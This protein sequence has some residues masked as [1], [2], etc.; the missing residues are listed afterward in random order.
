MPIT[1]VAA[2][3]QT[4]RTHNLLEPA[5]LDEVTQ[6]LQARFTDPRE[7]A[8]DLVRR[9]WLTGFQANYIT[10]GKAA[11]L[12]LSSFI[13]L[14]NCVFLSRRGRGAPHG[15]CGSKSSSTAR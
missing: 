10:Q 8:R 2:L 9:G 15:A 6:S 4:L 3:I 1:P 5:Q 13:L 11:E 7:L 12:V 14:A